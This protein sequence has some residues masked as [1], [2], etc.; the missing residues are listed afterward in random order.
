MPE[1]TLYHQE[2]LQGL[3]R[4]LS[5]RSVSVVVTS[6][7]YNIGVKYATYADTRPRNEYLAWMERV[8]EEVHRV[9]EPDG[10]FFLNLG[11]KPEDPW[12]AWDVANRL[13]KYFVLQNVI[14]WV[15]S[16]AIPKEDVG[17][18]PNIKGDIAVG[19][20]KPISSPRFLHDCHEFIF[21][22]TKSG[23]VKLDRLAVGVPYQDKSNIGRWKAARADLRCRGNTWFIPYET[24]RDRN[25]QRPH[26]STF[27][28][29]LPEMCIRLHGLS[30]TRLVL[31]PFMGIGSTAIACLRLGVP[32]VGFEIDDSYL[33]WAKRRLEEEQRRLPQNGN[34][35]YT[36]HLRPLTQEN[37]LL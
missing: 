17:R 11:N 33:D 13:R 16:I 30:K 20:Y 19:H 36:S 27:P 2:C 8:G 22:F 18:Y 6:P 14:H 1:I 4:H 28:V 7:P 24:I 29:K 34:L 9:L 10:S 15:K 21:H 26:P 31:D 12:I 32:C 23:S 5:P 37:L 25:R 3:R 35:R